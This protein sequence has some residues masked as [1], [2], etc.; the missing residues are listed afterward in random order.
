MDY[1]EKQLE[2][3]KKFLK[4]SSLKKALGFY[5]IIAIFLCGLCYYATY[6]FCEGWKN[7][8]MSAEGVTD[9]VV[10]YKDNEGYIADTVNLPESIKNKMYFLEVLESL[11]VLVYASIAIVMV[12]HMYY[13]NKLR[14]PLEILKKEME[15]MGRDDLSLDCRYLSG[16]EMGDICEAFNRMRLQLIDNRKNVWKLVKDQRE[17]NA[18]F[19]HDIRTPLTVMKGYTQILRKF[20]PGGQISE[21]KLFEMLSL[22]ENQVDRLEEFSGTMKEINTFEDLE[23]KREKSTAGELLSQIEKLLFGME[24]SGISARLNCEEGYEGEEIFLDNRAALEVAENLISNALRYAREK[25]QVQIQLENGKL[26]LYIKDDGAGFDKRA[27][28]NAKKPYFT[29]EKGHFGIG[30]TICKLLCEKHGGT[31]E[32]TNGIHGGGIVCASFFIL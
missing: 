8:I 30:L 21:E 9:Y 6:L 13:K 4:N 26:F 16:D 7:V 28:L 27:L 3:I 29:T 12:S 19:A 18:A 11:S 22:I 23:L 5:I 14:E 10:I 17:L 1:V 2:K 24:A 20:Q 31:L 32:M 15:A 25:I